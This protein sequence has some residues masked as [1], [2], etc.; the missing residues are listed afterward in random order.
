MVFSHGHP[1]SLECGQDLEQRF[2]KSDIRLTHF[3]NSSMNIEMISWLL[4]LA[5]NK[6]GSWHSREELDL[7]NYIGDNA[8]HAMMTKDDEGRTDHAMMTK[9]DEG[10]T[11]VKSEGQGG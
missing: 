11:L 3:S 4:L 7:E 1:S 5:C 6:G 8:D 9:D 10:R 2:S